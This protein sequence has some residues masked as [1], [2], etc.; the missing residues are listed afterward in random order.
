MIKFL[1]DEAQIA[2]KD[3]QPTSPQQSGKTTDVMKNIYDLEGNFFEWTQEANGS[4]S[5]TL[6]GG[7]YYDASNSNWDPA[8][9][10]IGGNPTGAY[11]NLSSRSALYVTL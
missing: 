9:Y 10:W 6:R 3:R 5:R 11:G 4:S 7:S 2:H 1:G 8:S